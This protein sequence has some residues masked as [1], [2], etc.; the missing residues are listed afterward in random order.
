M[1]IT[2]NGMPSI[3]FPPTTAF[4][5]TDWFEVA[6]SFDSRVNLPRVMAV[7]A[8]DE[9]GTPLPSLTASCVHIE[10]PNGLPPM[11]MVFP[12]LQAVQTIDFPVKWKIKKPVTD[13]PVTF[14][15]FGTGVSAMTA[16]SVV[17]D[18]IAAA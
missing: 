11:P 4:V 1:S 10:L 9:N 6:A 2:N 3:M 14:V 7:C 18:D 13:V 16:D 12:Q 8:V 15:M 17:R 5:E